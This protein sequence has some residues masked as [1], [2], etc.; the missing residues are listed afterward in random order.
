MGNHPRNP[1]RSRFVTDGCNM[2]DEQRLAVYFG[3][4]PETSKVMREGASW[5]IVGMTLEG[6]GRAS[7]YLC[8]ASETAQESDAAAVASTMIE[9]YKQE[10][11]DD[12]IRWRK[13]AQS[14]RLKT[15]DAWQRL[16][17]Y[18]NHCALACD[19]RALLL[20]GATL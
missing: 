11:V 14:A 6:F 9:R 16:A 15:G 3:M 13:M 17:E 20:I 12:G 10:S 19:A 4:L 8:P 1:P 18:Y 5:R 7:A 2:T